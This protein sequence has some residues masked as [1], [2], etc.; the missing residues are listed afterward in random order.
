MGKGCMG[1]KKHYDFGRSTPQIAIFIVALPFWS[2]YNLTGGSDV[3]GKAD[4]NWMIKVFNYF[5][6]L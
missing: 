2:S 5:R 6:S 4:P 3:K 1:E